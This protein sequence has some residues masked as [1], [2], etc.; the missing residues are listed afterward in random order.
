VTSCPVV[1]SNAEM[2]VPRLGAAGVVDTMS[3]ANVFSR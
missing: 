1:S 2:C 3:K